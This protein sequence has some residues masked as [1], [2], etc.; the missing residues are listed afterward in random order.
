MSVSHKQ[1]IL[2][3]TGIQ[4]QYYLTQA[5]SFRVLRNFLVE[6][7]FEKAVICSR[8]LRFFINLGPKVIYQTHYK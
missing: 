1:T 6:Y 7:T 2:T 5:Y 4:M 8:H 3:P